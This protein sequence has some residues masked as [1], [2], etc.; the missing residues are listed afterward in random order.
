MRATFYIQNADLA[1]NAEVL[2]IFKNA[3][4]RKN[5]RFQPIMKRQG[6]FRELVEEA[7]P[8]A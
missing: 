6:H 8:V 1:K 7:P 5:R 3:G 2:G 4:K